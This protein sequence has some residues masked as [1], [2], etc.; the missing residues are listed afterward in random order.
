MQ[1]LTLA[2]ESCRVM[3][4]ISQKALGR[5]YHGTYRRMEVMSGAKD[6]FP[7]DYD[8][9]NWTDTYKQ[10]YYANTIMEG[11]NSISITNANQ[12]KWNNIKGSALF[13][14]AYAHFKLMQLFSLPYDKNS[15]DELLGVPIRLT[16]NISEPS[17]RSS[18]RFCYDRILTD[19]KDAIGL[20]PDQSQIITRPSKLAAYG[21]LSR[22]YLSIDEF[23]NAKLYADSFLLRYSILTD[24][25]ELQAAPYTLQ[26]ST[27][28]YVLEDVFHAT[29][30]GDIITSF[31]QAIVDSA[32]F[33]LY[34]TNDLRRTCYFTEYNGELRFK[35]SFESRV[36]G[37]FFSGIATGEILLNRAEANIRLDKIQ[38]G[39]DDI[40]TL[41]SKRYITGKFTNIS[42]GSKSEALTIALNER[43]KELCFRGIRWLDLRRLNKELEHAV[44]LK[45]V[46]GTQE[47]TLP[48][49]DP[50]YALPIPY[51][52]VLVS[53]IEQNE[54]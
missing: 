22:I 27:E 5:A 26:P 46:L 21:M 35:G 51:N 4:I 28:P 47:F 8:E 7:I 45:R 11:L 39:I 37:G 32:I 13:F 31:T 19:M 6:I 3:I 24:F 40:N 1:Q 23:E 2:L 38:E 10:V 43:R 14:R 49:N 15:S 9:P 48:P 54:R 33:Q 53:G 44:T 18:Q 25:N 17:V 30:G 34:D 20:L 16:S 50:R 41:L 36:F 42:A 12:Q 52:E 29:F